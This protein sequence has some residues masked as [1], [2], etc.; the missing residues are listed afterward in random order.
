M[1]IPSPNIAQHFA[2]IGKHFANI[3]Q[4]FANIG[5]HFSREAQDCNPLMKV[6]RRV[7]LVTKSMQSAIF[8]LANIIKYYHHLIMLLILF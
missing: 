5:K 8:E 6:G 1:I 4:H 7:Y 2:N 3:A